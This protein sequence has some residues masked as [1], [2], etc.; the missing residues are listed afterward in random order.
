VELRGYSISLAYDRGNDRKGLVAEFE[1]SAGPLGY[2]PYGVGAL[3]SLSSSGAETSS[4]V[5]VG[6]G[7]GLDKNLL[8]PFVAMDWR[9]SEESELDL[10]LEY[11]YSDG[12]ASL[13]YSGG[14]GS[15]LRFRF[16]KLF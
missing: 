4:R 5:H 13:V 16:E 8:Q 2:D 10:G 14:N 1:Q 7:I 12:R 6:Y 9:E 3:S 15:N 11:Q